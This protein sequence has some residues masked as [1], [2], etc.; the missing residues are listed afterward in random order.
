MTAV[1]AIVLVLGFV[2]LLVWIARSAVAD[3]V[4]GW[5]RVDPEVR[6]GVRGRLTVAGTFGFGLAGMSAT[7]AGWP[8]A[9]ALAAAIGGVAF[10]VG[11]AVRYGPDEAASEDAERAN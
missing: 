1:Y 2:G 6:F 5:E 10:A 9:G 11:I 7:F 3:T 8:V 4:E